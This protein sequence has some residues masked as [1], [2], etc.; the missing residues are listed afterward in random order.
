MK[1][2]IVWLLA[3]CPVVFALM[4]DRPPSEVWVDSRTGQAYVLMV[5]PSTSCEDIKPEFYPDSSLPGL[6]FQASIKYSLKK[7]SP[8]YNRFGFG[9]SGEMAKVQS[10][11]SCPE[12]WTKVESFR[13][14]GSEK[15]FQCDKVLPLP[16]LTF[17]LDTGISRTIQ[18]SRIEKE[19][20]LQNCFRFGLYSYGGAGCSWG[21]FPDYF[22][23]FGFRD[24][25]GFYH[26][27]LHRRDFDYGKGYYKSYL[28]YESDSWHC[29]LGWYDVMGSRRFNYKHVTCFYDLPDP[30]PF[31][32]KL[33]PLKWTE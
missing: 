3:A 9:S 4:S 10:V 24:D 6:G 8:K 25:L 2:L 28:F 23:V 16:N 30:E 19:M 31:G 15:T 18:Y 17:F 14:R 20:I 5:T 13:R 12:G 32:E 22:Q 26:E 33:S 21:G 27:V 7:Y 29:A 1:S 11:D